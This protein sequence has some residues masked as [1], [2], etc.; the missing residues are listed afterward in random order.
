MPLSWKEG[1]VNAFPIPQDRTK[2]RYVSKRDKHNVTISSELVSVVESLETVSLEGDPFPF[3]DLPG[4]IRNRI[5]QLVLFGKPGYRVIHGRMRPSRIGIMLANKLTHREAAYV[6]Y[7]TSSFRIFPLQ[8]FTPAPVIQ[9]LRPMY[10]DMVTSLEMVVGSSWTS[11]PKTWRVGKLLAKRL[12]KLSAV[13]TLKIFVELDPSLPM[14]E[15]YR[16]SLDF[17]TDFCGDLLR[18]VLACMPHL[19]HIEINGNPG[20]DTTGPL[21]SRL[22]QEVEAK[23]K[24]CT[25]GP[26][27]AMPTPTGVKV[28]FW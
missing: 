17:Y 22:L 18:D 25:L 28:A 14:F 20:I 9:E 26:T 11:P 19:S 24:T 2:L 8:D 27:K 10:R 15:K 6:L 21:V 7:S 16:V 1:L 23:G 4:E 13:N 12:S 5:Y 3:L